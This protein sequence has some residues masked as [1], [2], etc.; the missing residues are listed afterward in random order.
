MGFVDPAVSTWLNSIF[1]RCRRILRAVFLCFPN[2]SQVGGK[3]G[4]I[5]TSSSLSQIH[6]GWRIIAVNGQRL[7][8]EEVS[9]ALAAAQKMAKYT[10]TFGLEDEA[11]NDLPNGDRLD[12]ERKERERFDNERLEKARLEKERSEKERLE[13]E[14]LEKERLEKERLEKE[15]RD[16]QEKERLA[17]ARDEERKQEAEK[18]AAREVAEKSFLG[19]L[20]VDLSLPPSSLSPS[21]SLFL[22]QSPSL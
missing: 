17:K 20:F 3:L 1:K 14:R 10:V 13:K 11:K 8:A 15:R 22:L 7:A 12:K 5:V 9:K 16:E 2:V 21:G 6:R 4:N 18:R 19:Q